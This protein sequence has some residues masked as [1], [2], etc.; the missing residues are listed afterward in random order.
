M[1]YQ[2]GYLARCPLIQKQFTSHPKVI[3]KHYVTPAPVTS[4]MSQVSSVTL[5]PHILA[6]AMCLFLLYHLTS[7]SWLAVLC[8]FIT[9]HPRPN[10]VSSDGEFSLASARPRHSG[11]YQC[12]AE[13]E[14]E[15]VVREVTLSVNCEY[16]VEGR[17]LS[18]L[19]YRRPSSGAGGDPREEA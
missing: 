11:V 13:A 17:T 2:Q 18:Y 1:Y 19:P 16:T 14:G 4:N 7:L 8:Y 6:L 12:V 9:S 10:Q 3:Q 5:Y 15:E